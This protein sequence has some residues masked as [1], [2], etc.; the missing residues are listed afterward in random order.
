MVKKQKVTFE[1]TKPT[2]LPEAKSCKKWNKDEGYIG[3]FKS[4]RENIKTPNG[5]ASIYCFTNSDEYGEVTDKYSYFW[6]SSAFDNELKGARIG[7]L[8]KITCLGNDKNPKSG[9]TYVKFKLKTAQMFLT[10]EQIA[11]NPTAAPVQPD[12][13]EDD[14]NCEIDWD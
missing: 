6:S 13:V 7:Q 14:F 2:N 9:R 11:I 4:I 8:C 3:Y 5:T 10:A 1:E 12:V